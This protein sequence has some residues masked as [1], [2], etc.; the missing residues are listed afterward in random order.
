MNYYVFFSVPRK[1]QAVF[2]YLLKSGTMRSLTLD[3]IAA[4][5]QTDCFRYGREA[6]G[7]LCSVETVW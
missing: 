6:G 2:V 5:L 1:V 7:L 3:V 4:S